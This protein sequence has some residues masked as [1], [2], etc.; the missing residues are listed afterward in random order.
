MASVGSRWTGNGLLQGGFVASARPAWFLSGCL[1]PG[2]TAVLS[3]GSGFFRVNETVFLLKPLDE[4]E[5][6]QHAVY[7]ASHLRM[8]RSACLEAALEYDHDPKIAAPL[9]LYRWVRHCTD[10]SHCS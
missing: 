9:K 6:G 2:L 7:R 5:A 10:F 4:H 3:L 8:K 1:H